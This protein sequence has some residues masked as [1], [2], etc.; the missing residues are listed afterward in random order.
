MHEIQRVFVEEGLPLPAPGHMSVA[1]SRH[2]KHAK[3]CFYRHPAFFVPLN[4]VPLESAYFKPIAI[5]TGFPAG[6]ET[7][8]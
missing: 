8:R 7:R 5:V 1:C 4:H 6:R 2:R 3:A